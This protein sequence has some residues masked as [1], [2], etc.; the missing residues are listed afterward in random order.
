MSRALSRPGLS[1]SGPRLSFSHMTYPKSVF[2]KPIPDFSQ[3]KFSQIQSNSGI[4]I[5]ILNQFPTVPPKIIPEKQKAP[6]PEQ[7]S[8]HLHRFIHEF[9]LRSPGFDPHSRI[10]PKISLYLALFWFRN[11]TCHLKQKIDYSANLACF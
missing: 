2:P 9:V 5:F 3:V 1:S 10:S 4:I 8:F 11:I 7:F 6:C